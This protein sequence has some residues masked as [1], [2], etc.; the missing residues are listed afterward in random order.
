[1]AEREKLSFQ[2]RY[3]EARPR[4]RIVE[5]FPSSV[6]AFTGEFFSKPFPKNVYPTP[7]M[8]AEAI[9]EYYARIGA[10]K[11][12]EQAITEGVGDM[13]IRTVAK[14]DELWERMGR[15]PKNSERSK[16]A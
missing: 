2:P 13:H 9:L 16:P 15:S 6:T 1:M 12:P 8:Q 7:K 14:R 4:W 3:D 11:A 5:R 10:S